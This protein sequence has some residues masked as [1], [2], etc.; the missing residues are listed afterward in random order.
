MLCGDER[1]LGFA[2]VRLVV[3]P[4]NIPAGE[5]RDRSN[6]SELGKSHIPC[7]GPSD[8]ADMKSS[9]SSLPPDLIFYG[10]TI[11]TRNM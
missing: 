9:F 1:Y 2:A 5:Q 11:T 3:A 6:P 8:Q 4:I 10:R 7:N